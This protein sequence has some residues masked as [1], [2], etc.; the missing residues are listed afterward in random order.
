MARKLPRQAAS[1]VQSNGG[2]SDVVSKDQHSTI[3]N[4]ETVAEME[5]MNIVCE[6]LERAIE[7]ENVRSIQSKY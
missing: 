2:V 4:P 5:N 6:L 3:N 7:Y 1:K